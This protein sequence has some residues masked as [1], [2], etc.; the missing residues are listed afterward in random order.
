MDKSGHRD[1]NNKWVDESIP[2]KLRNQLSPL[3]TLVDILSEERLDKLLRS[4][5]G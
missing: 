2:A 4:E 1:I 5:D 3:C